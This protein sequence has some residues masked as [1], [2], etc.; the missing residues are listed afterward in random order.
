[1]GSSLEKRP[2]L[3][4]AIITAKSTG[5]PLICTT[6]DRLGRNHDLPVREVLDHGISTIT[7]S[8]GRELTDEDFKKEA[9]TNTKEKPSGGPPSAL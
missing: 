9:L 5:F 2:E 8:H 3:K 6:L 1:M 4:Q 7:T